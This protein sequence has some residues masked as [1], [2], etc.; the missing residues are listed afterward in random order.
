MTF[1]DTGAW[2]ASFS[3]ADAH[4]DRVDAW[5]AANAQQ[6]VTTDYCVDETLTLLLKRDRVD[7]AI[8]AARILFDERLATLHYLTRSQIQRAAVL[9]QQRA[10][11]GWSFTDCTSKIVIDDLRITSALA[12]DEH[13]AQFGVA[14]LP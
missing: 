4:H 6:L 5:L 11:D 7:T 10:A 2:F 12:L 3:A 1:V 9:F 14:V 13:F 8:R